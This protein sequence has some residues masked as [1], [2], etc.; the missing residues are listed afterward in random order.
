MSSSLWPHGL[1]Q[2]RLPHPLPSPRAC[3]NHVHWVRDAIQPSHLFCPFSWCLLS[4]PTSGS[5]IFS[6][7]IFHI[8]FPKYWSFSFSISPSNENSELIYFR[9]D[10]FD[11]LAVQGTLNSLLQ[12]HSLKALIL[13]HPAFFM[14]QLSHPYMTTGK[15][16]A[17][18]LWT[19][20]GKVMSLFFNIL[21]RFVIAFL[22][23]A[24]IF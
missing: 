16:I 19:F 5:W 14:G 13:Q 11:L 10:W 17:L 8:R 20:V 12:H 24:N 21:S 3:S 7:N 4:F 1:Q 23:R 15:T 9:T 18:T 22:P 2:A 6:E